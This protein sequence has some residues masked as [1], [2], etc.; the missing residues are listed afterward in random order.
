MLAAARARYP[1]TAHVAPH[2]G[3]DPWPGDESLN[4]ILPFLAHNGIA[5]PTIGILDIG[6]MLTEDRKVYAPL[7]D[8]N[9][10]RV[11]G[12]EPVAQECAKL[13]RELHGTSTTYLP[14]FVGDG[15]EQT[16]RLSNATMTSSLYEPNAELLGLFVKLLELTTTVKREQVRTTRLDDIP[17]IDFPADFVKIDIQGA[18]LQA[19]SHGERVLRDVTVIQTEVEW[20]AM[21]HQ[22]PLFAEVGQELRRQGFVVHRILTFG[23]RRFKPFLINNDP[24]NGYQH[25]WSDVVFVRD[26]CRLD[27][28]SERQLLSYAI[29]VSEL[30]YAPDLACHVC[31]SMGV[32]SA[33]PSATCTG[34][35][36]WDPGDAG[37][38]ALPAIDR[39]VAKP[40][41]DAG[42]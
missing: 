31:R 27:V 33:G 34:R 13:N 4:P 36:S 29:L 19:F 26:F 18:E 3:V 10:A 7:L 1:S 42:C 5:V 21:Y 24:D 28:L 35:G 39:R 15:T 38:E 12:F 9:V 25:L 17:E 14:Y 40:G 8:A 37:D 16:F 30:Y 20:V 22:Q 6:A 23:S 41:C 11:V 32:G 2:G